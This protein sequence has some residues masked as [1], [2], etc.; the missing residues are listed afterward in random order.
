MRTTLRVHKVFLHVSNLGLTENLSPNL[1]CRIVR[2]CPGIHHEERTIHHGYHP[3]AAPCSKGSVA[4]ITLENANGMRVTLLSYGATIQSILVPD[5]DGRM[6]D[7][8]LGYDRAADYEVNSGYLGACIGRN[9]NRIA[10]AAFC[11]NGR[12]YT[13]TA[14]EGKNQLHTVCAASTRRSGAI[15]AARTV[16]NSP[17]CSP[18]A[19]RASRPDGGRHHLYTRRRNGLHIDYRAVSDRDTVA[20]LRTTPTL[21]STAT[22]A[23][24]FLGHT[25]QL[26]ASAF[27][28]PRTS[29]LMPTGEITPVDGTCMDFRAPKTIGSGI[30]DPLLK[31]FGGYDNNFCLDGSG[32]RKVAEAAGDKSGIVMDVE[33]TLEGVQPLHRQLPV[34]PHRQGRRALRPFGGF[35]LETQHYPDAINQPAFPSPVLRRGEQLH[36]TTIYRFGVRKVRS[37]AMISLGIDIGGTGCKCVAFRDNGEQVALSYREYPTKPGEVNLDALALRESVFFVISDCVRKLEDPKDVAAITVSSFGESFVPVDKDGQP[38]TDI[39]LY[40]ANTESGAFT[41]LVNSIGAEK[42][43]RITCVLPDASYSLAKMLYSLKR[44]RAPVWK[45]PVHRELHLLLPVR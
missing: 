13:L 36:E 20:N 25:L 32:L 7:V 5:K 42:F 14:N 8:L 17:P 31:P 12:R 28:P 9:G 15:P 27:T 23:A 41:D 43:M 10:R 16:W 37:R 39:I 24:T 44:R 26:Q 34:R 4:S 19:K 21:T 3:K 35:C 30:H 22:A 45:V 2:C 38:L 11:L 18:T 29:I 33:T 40:F 1:L 6:T